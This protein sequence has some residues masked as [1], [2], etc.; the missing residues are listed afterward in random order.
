ML[1]LLPKDE[2]HSAQTGTSFDMINSKDAF[3]LFEEEGTVG[4]LCVDEHN[5][6]FRMRLF[7]QRNW[8]PRT[9]Q[10]RYNSE[11]DHAHS[12]AKGFTLE[13]AYD[14]VMAIR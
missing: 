6:L 5:K 12:G 11:I 8:L 3:E 4:H 1:P 2:L 9:S 13:V 7:V 10:F 14:M